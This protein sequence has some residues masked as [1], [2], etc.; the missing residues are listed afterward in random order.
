MAE[1]VARRFWHFLDDDDNAPATVWHH[2]EDGTYL[3]GMM[4]RARRSLFDPPH[5][6]TTVVDFDEGLPEPRPTLARVLE[7]PEITA[8][9]PLDAPD[10]LTE[11][12]IH[13]PPVS[14]AAPDDDF[15]A[16]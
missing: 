6:E 10:S 1:A 5:P 9:P 13:V 4:H 15:A 14:E 11:A 2:V 3:L 7:D 12:F 8:L 16:Q